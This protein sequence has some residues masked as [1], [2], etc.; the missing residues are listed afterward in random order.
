MQRKWTEEFVSFDFL[1]DLARQDDTE[2][3]SLLLG[4]TNGT[5]SA[6]GGLS[7]L[8]THTNS[9][10]VTETTVSPEWNVITEN[11]NESEV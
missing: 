10:V 6:T 5:T 4:H 3:T 7:V 9:P 11:I 1:I 8:S 2:L